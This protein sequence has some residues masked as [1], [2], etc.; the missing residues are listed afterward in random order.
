[1][2]SYSAACRFSSTADRGR[3]CS[4]QKCSMAECSDVWCIVAGLM[5]R[6]AMGE[7]FTQEVGGT[8]FFVQVD[9]LKLLRYDAQHGRS[10]LQRRICRTQVWKV[11]ACWCGREIKC[12]GRGF[13]QSSWLREVLKEMA[14]LRGMASGWGEVTQAEVWLRVRME[15]AE[16]W[17]REVT[18]YGWVDTAAWVDRNVCISNAE[19]KRKDNEQRVICL[20]SWEKND[21]K[22]CGLSL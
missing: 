17:R 12:D 13:R 9:R 4:F 20:D 22:R 10:G 6:W 3:F 8:R 5:C 18:A 14:P 16:I 19:K 2:I 1:M 15:Y 7:N 11:A 21:L